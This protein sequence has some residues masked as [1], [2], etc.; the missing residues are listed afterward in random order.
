MTQLSES[1][2]ASAVEPLRRELLTHCYRMLGSLPDAEEALQEALVRAWQGLPSFEGRAP[3]RRWLYRIATRTSLD[4]LESRKLRTLPIYDLPASDPAAALPAPLLEGRWVEPAP[5]AALELAVEAAPDALLSGKE[6]VA[7]AFLAALQHLP[8]SQRAVLVLFDVAG[9]SAEEVA[10]I[11]ELTVP[12]TNS[13]LQRARDTL[14][15]H[16]ADPPRRAADAAAIEVVRKLVAAL[17]AAD[18]G[19]LVQLVREDAVFSMPPL[20]FWVSGRDA[21]EQFHRDT[22]FARMPAGSCRYEIVH[23]NGCPGFACW[24]RD[25]QGVFQ[26]ATVDIIVV[27][28]DGIHE[29]HAFLALDPALGFERFAGVD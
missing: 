7:L 21:I 25:D 22:V 5:D 1:E 4:R 19:A 16:R 26:P 27:A 8:P 6:S 13:A 20:P 12:A 15:K 23:A 11:L 29:I 18:V 3:L 14:S 2:F 24:Q 17:D 28:E 10:G 9:Y